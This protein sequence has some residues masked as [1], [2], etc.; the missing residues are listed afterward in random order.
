M[1]TEVLGFKEAKGDSVFAAANF[2]SINNN[3]A[4]VI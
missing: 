1:G 4:G 2:L 3:S